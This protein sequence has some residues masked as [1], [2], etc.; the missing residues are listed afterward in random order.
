MASWIDDL[1]GVLEDAF[2]G[3]FGT[4]IFTGYLPDDP[5]NAIVLR[6]YSGEATP[7]HWEGE[8]TMAQILVRRADWETAES[9][10]RAALEALHGVSETLIGSNRY[11]VIQA[12]G[13]PADL[14]RDGRGRSIRSVSFTIL[15]DRQ[16]LGD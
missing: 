2:L 11:L 10:A 6:E 1:A 7:L 16:P 8:R 14:G 3:T 13:S 5:D 4:D 15:R 9:D 12:T